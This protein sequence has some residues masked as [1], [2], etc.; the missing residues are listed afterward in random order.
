[1]LV[2][3]RKPNFCDPCLQ[4]ADGARELCLFIFVSISPDLPQPEGLRFKSVRE[5]SVEVMW[6]Q[7]DISFDGWEIYFRNTVSLPISFEGL[8]GILLSDRG[9]SERWYTHASLLEVSAKHGFISALTIKIALTCGKTSVR[10]SLDV[11]ELRINLL[12]RIRASNSL[13]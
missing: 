7:L 11:I 1:M 13:K 6:D 8:P 5:T 4:F 9:K 12:L 10:A 3:E 2:G